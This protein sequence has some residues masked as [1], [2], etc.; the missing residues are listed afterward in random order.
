MSSAPYCFLLPAL[1]AY[2]RLAFDKKL[3]DENVS[4]EVEQ[5]D[6]YKVFEAYNFS[7]YRL[8]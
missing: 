4:Y 2:A 3:F 7:S 8:R 1:A 6:S 5:N